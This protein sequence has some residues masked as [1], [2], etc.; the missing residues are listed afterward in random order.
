M[1]RMNTMPTQK[2][3]T[4]RRSQPVVCFEQKQHIRLLR[5]HIV[6]FTTELGNYAY[7][8]DLDTA[9]KIEDSEIITKAFTDKEHAPKGLFDLFIEAIR[10]GKLCKPP[11]NLIDA[12][13]YGN[14]HMRARGLDPDKAY[15]GT[16]IIEFTWA[17][18]SM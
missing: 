2:D 13:Y 16:T 17:K 3:L 4:E 12:K 7:S 8:P 9:V 15:L 14:V 18:K 5:L 11:M 6:L 10:S 1:D